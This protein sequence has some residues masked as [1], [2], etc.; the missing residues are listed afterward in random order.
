MVWRNLKIS[1][2][3]VSLD[4]SITKSFSDAN[5]SMPFKRGYQGREIYR[6]DV[7]TA[8]NSKPRSGVVDIK[9]IERI[10]NTRDIKQYVSVDESISDDS[11]SDCT[12]ESSED[13]DNQ[14]V[15]VDPE[16][17]KKL[18]PKTKDVQFLKIL[19]LKDVTPDM[20]A[21][22]HYF[23]QVKNSKSD[24]ATPEQKQRLA[25]ISK[26]LGHNGLALLVK[27]T[28][29]NKPI[30]AIM[31]GKLMQP[32]T[33]EETG[34]T[35]EPRY[36]LKMSNIFY[37]E[38]QTSPIWELQPEIKN[39]PKTIE[40]N[41]LQRLKAEQIKGKLHDIIHTDEY[42]HKVIDYV[43]QL[44]TEGKPIDVESGATADS[45]DSDMLGLAIWMSPGKMDDKSDSDSELEI[46]HT[47]ATVHSGCSSSNPK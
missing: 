39:V 38:F 12:S 13:S 26:F 14:L 45:V 2:A 25:F 34:E 28:P 35:P 42:Y 8:N 16:V 33:D 7:A 24:Q 22:S 27:Y 1:I 10:L 15:P 11:E 31:Y 36:I 20:Y 29:M 3:G 6:L 18:C 19:K 43:D 4:V 21:G 17:L 47:T 37:D 41:F 23:V 32:P 46:D 30:Y 44:R 40:K 5:K 9:N